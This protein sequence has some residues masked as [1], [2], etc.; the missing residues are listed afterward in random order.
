MDLTNTFNIKAGQCSAHLVYGKMLISPPFSEFVPV[1][2]LTILFSPH[3]SLCHSCIQHY[4]VADSNI[5]HFL[6]LLSSLAYFGNSLLTFLWE[7]HHSFYWQLN[8]SKGLDWTS[9]LPWWAPDF[10]SPNSKVNSSWSKYLIPNYY[11]STM[12]FSIILGS[13]S[14]VVFFNTL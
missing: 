1:L 9:C 8:D 11:G 12:G 10:T 4:L 3:S 5:R 6:S 2:V 14:V 7:N 13:T